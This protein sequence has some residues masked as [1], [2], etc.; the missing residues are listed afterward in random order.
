[1]H[2]NYK[3]NDQILGIFVHEH[4]LLID[5][6]QETNIDFA[7]FVFLQQL[8]SQIHQ[9]ICGESICVIMEQCDMITPN[10]AIYFCVQF[11]VGCIS[12]L[13]DMPMFPL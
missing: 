8:Q 13:R 3:V 4:L 7:L 12:T 9:H 10:V 1:M 5:F 2:I 6:H 11:F